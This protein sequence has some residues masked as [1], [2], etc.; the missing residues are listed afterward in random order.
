[1]Q[2]DNQPWTFNRSPKKILS[3]RYQAMGDVV[4][5]L[6]YLHFIKRKFPDTE[7]H[8]L[9][10]QEVADIPKSL[11]LFD[12]VISIKG[13]RSL[14]G[15]FFFTVLKLPFLL[16]QRYEMALDL[17]NHRLSRLVR[18]LL[19]PD[20]WCS[21][22]KYSP[23]P[24]GERIQLTFGTLQ[25]TSVHPDTQFN[26]KSPPVLTMSILKKHGWNEGSRLIILNPAGAFPSR[27]WPLENYVA[28]AKLFKKEF[29]DVQFLVVG[30][31]SKLSEAAWNLK[32]ELPQCVINLTGKTSP[33]EAF[34]IVK[35][36][37]LIITEDS[38]LMHMAWV[39][40]V[41]TLALFGSTRSDWSRPLG[42]SSHCLDSSDL[43]CG[44]CM[45]EICK[46]GD[47][48]CLTRYS[49]EFIFETAQAL[50]RHEK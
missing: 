40:G 12:K 42:D 5:T 44:N 21:F 43:S 25:W 41:P 22:D 15:Q 18:K 36:A 16:R 45:L 30:L 49:P 48:R 3:I 1:M 6:P 27:H 2:G 8:F 24:A 26:L 35:Q 46:W 11:V 4:I 17:Q 33:S 19:A 7:L 37:S 39:Q 9:T 31:S 47:N 32:S 34:A 10:R 28:F 20:A 13:G 29:Q 14:L 50:L 38:G 23:L